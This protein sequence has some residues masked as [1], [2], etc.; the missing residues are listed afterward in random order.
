M[1]VPTV[2][3]EPGEFEALQ[4]R[5]AAF[6]EAL[7]AGAAT[8]PLVLSGHDLNV[9]LARHPDTATWRDRAHLQVVGDQVV[10]QVSLPLDDLASLPGM[11][12]FR[13][14]YLNGTAALRPSLRDGQLAVFL[15][16]LEV[17]GQ[18]LPENVMRSLRQQNL[19]QDAQFDP[20]M[21]EALARLENI[22]VSDGQIIIRPAQ[23]Q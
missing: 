5:M 22:E 7:Q 9:L 4:Q 2:Q 10:G 16:S 6:Q 17:N 13:G 18:P 3:V 1:A 8:S 14:R 20:E 12:R 23:S 19:A 15:E 11:K 21:S